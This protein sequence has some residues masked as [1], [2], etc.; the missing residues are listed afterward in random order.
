[1]QS[2]FLSGNEKSFC[3][4]FTEYFFLQLKAVAGNGRNLTSQSRI[5]S[6]QMIEDDDRQL[7]V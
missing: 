7:F 2:V 6:A 1:M 5:F 4:G 3:Y